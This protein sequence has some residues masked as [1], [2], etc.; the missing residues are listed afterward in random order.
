MGEG[1][2]TSGFTRLDGVL[3]CDG[4]PLDRI[5]AEVGT[6]TYVYSAGTVRDRFERLDSAVAGLPHRIHYT[7]KANSNAAI[8]RLL[9][10]LG[11][12]ADVVSGGELFRARR[13]GFAPAEII[14]GGVGKTER[15][16]REALQ[17]G[18]MLIN[19]E[20][21]DE[22][23]LLDR[24]AGELGVVAPVG[25]RVNPEVA[26]D[27]SHRYIKT[28]EKG[29]KFGIPF[30]EVLAVAQVASSLP[31]TRLVGL[32]MHIG[33]QIFRLDPYLDGVDRLAGLLAALRTA[34][35]D[36]IR[37]LDIGGGLGVAYD[38]EQSPDLVRFA[39]SLVPRVRATGLT[40][41]MEP[42]RFIVGNAGVLLT[43]VLY[44][45]H[46][47]GRDFLITDA[48]MTEL[49]RPSHYDA[50]HRIEPVRASAGRM[51][52]DVVGPVCESGDFL[53]LG[54]EMSQANAGDLLAVYD[55][56]A[57]GYVMASNY[58]TRPRGAEVLVDADRYAVV[59]ARERYEDLVRLEQDDPEWRQG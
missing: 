40:L 24:I 37:Y 20:S 5:A 51:T 16:L 8:L 21:G 25:L 17:A 50:Y 18:V 27:S 28:G 15:E 26:V 45:K 19:V 14:F 48:G 4:V 39:A 3:A 53:A 59:T 9:R 44:R 55:V 12:G 33:S 30:D 2:L 6:P 41:L 11:A 35:V 32:D 1:V 56:G 57:Y 49:I 7:L 58:N 52:A 23:R 42:G 13:A 36:S 10:Q 22:V 31:N 54:R 46:S 38:D 34:G 47:G 43:R 29:A